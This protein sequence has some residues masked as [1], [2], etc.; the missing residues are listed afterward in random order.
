VR[1]AQH[2]LPGQPAPTAPNQVWVGN[3]TY[4]PKQGGG[5]LYLVTWQTWLGSSPLKTMRNAA[6][7][8]NCSL[9]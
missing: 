6:V 5:W 8:L 4:L 9:Y 1:T 2:R 7:S 3:I